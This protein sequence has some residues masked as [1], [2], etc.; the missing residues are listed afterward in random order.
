MKEKE[1]TF[2]NLMNKFN[3]EFN[4][5]ANFEFNNNNKDIECLF[6][7]LKTS[8]CEKFDDLKLKIDE[9][10][11]FFNIESPRLDANSYNYGELNEVISIIK[12]LIEDY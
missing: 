8:L 12:L 11:L 9:I 2:I 5:I 10:L 6:N 4:L 7:I 3:L 1:N